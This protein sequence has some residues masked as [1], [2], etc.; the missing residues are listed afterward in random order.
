LVSTIT[1]RWIS[2]GS[3]NTRRRRAAKPT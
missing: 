2:T 3:V 1:D